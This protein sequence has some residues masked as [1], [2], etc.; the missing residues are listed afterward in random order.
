M[1][2]SNN[3]GSRKYSKRGATWQN[4][5]ALVTPRGRSARGIRIPSFQN[6]FCFVAALSLGHTTQCHHNH[7]YFPPSYPSWKKTLTWYSCGKTL[8][9][10]ETSSEKGSRVV[11]SGQLQP[12]HCFL[13]LQ[14]KVMFMST[15]LLGHW[16][17]S[18]ST[19]PST[20]SCSGIQLEGTGDMAQLGTAPSRSLPR[21]MQPDSPGR[22]MGARQAAP[23]LHPPG[24]L[25]LCWLQN[26]CS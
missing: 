16:L 18:S 8:S 21:T 19:Y 26:Q 20:A 14:R 24:G 23:A 12:L 25:C 3:Q 5:T 9:V 1:L 13:Q 15:L 6:Q 11:P 10:S 22:R 4:P 7:H 17:C 2:Y